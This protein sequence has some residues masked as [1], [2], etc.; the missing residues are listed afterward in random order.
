MNEN[1]IKNIILWPSFVIFVQVLC[2]V[3]GVIKI[4]TLLYIIPIV[5]SVS[6]LVSVALL[7]YYFE[8]KSSNEIRE[9]NNEI[10]K[11]HIEHMESLKIV[12]RSIP[13]L[14]HR[15][16]HAQL[17]IPEK[18]V[19]I[20][21]AVPK[22]NTTERAKIFI[23]YLVNNVKY[24]IIYLYSSSNN[25]KISNYCKEIYESDLIEKG[26]DI[27][28]R[29]QIQIVP[30]SEVQMSFDIF[31]DHSKNSRMLIHFPNTDP[32]LSEKYNVAWYIKDNDVINH[33]T[34]IFYDVW[35]QNIKNCQVDVEETAK[36]DCIV[37]KKDLF[38]LKKI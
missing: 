34:S 23:D 30:E 14:S 24:K 10:R 16:G 22:V 36:Q 9:E 38:H 20:M 28:N 12:A 27:I 32:F 35:G 13:M 4:R 7:I 31:D 1:K 25:D 18:S 2:Y 15:G 33:F 19:N 6:S 21:G 17:G 26:I 11:K 8:V 3:S 37:F 5:L 29:F